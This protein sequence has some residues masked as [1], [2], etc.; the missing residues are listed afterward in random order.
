MNLY[1]YAGSSPCNRVDP[2]ET[3]PEPPDPPE[4][5]RD[6]KRFV[7]G[8]GRSSSDYMAAASKNTGLIAINIQD[9]HNSP[10][11][12]GEF[13]PKFAGERFHPEQVFGTPRMLRGGGDLYPMYSGVMTQ[14]A[15]EGNAAGTVHADMRRL[16]LTPGLRGDLP[17]FSRRDFHSSSEA[18]QILAHLASTEPGER[19]VDLVIQHKK[20]I[21]KIPRHS[22]AVQGDPLPRHLAKH[23]PNINNT[24]SP[25]GGRKGAGLGG[26]GALLV[27]A[28]VVERL[29]SRDPKGA[30]QVVG[31]A[32]YDPTGAIGSYDLHRKEITQNA[33]WVG[34]RADEGFFTAVRRHSQG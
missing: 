20:G 29:W 22:N 25:G 7:V 31:F 14:A 26:L 13:F 10:L 23:V 33:N 1:E 9:K 3:N 24:P 18:R 8:L 32:L 4:P 27:G 2:G 11:G 5:A 34:E 6:P 16:E 21:T 19:K 15:L 12:L 28:Q 17:G 30:L